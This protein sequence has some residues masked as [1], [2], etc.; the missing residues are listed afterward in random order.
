MDG[1]VESNPA[2]VFKT[3]VAV[4]WCRLETRKGAVKDR[5]SVVDKIALIGTRFSAVR[6]ELLA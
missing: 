1:S 5:A 3:Q 6:G 2:A 4:L